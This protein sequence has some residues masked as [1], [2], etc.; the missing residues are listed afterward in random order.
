VLYQ[1]NDMKDHV[2]V[3]PGSSENGHLSELARSV[4]QIHTSLAI[5]TPD[6]LV[7][8]MLGELRDQIAHLS[9]ELTDAYIR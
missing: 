6:T 1:L 4:L 2:G 7:P 8:E 3:L 5:S 9:V